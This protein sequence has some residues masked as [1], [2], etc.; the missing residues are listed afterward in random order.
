MKACETALVRVVAPEDH[1]HGVP[2]RQDDRV[3]RSVL[4]SFLSV[5]TETQSLVCLGQHL[6]RSQQRRQ[7]ALKPWGESRFP[8]LGGL[9]P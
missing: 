4:I 5:A 7:A 9:S 6:V 3:S 8:L 2:G 1:R